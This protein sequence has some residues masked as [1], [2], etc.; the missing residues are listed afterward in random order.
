MMTASATERCRP[1]PIKARTLKIHHPL[2][3][4]KQE[5]EEEEVDP[6]VTA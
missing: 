1:S 3:D 4:W 2:V 5:E 6:M